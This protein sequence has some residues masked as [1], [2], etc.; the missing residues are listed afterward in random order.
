MPLT[1]N[2]LLDIEAAALREAA[3][4]E[5]HGRTG[6]ARDLKHI[7]S[8]A[9][10][11]ADLRFPCPASMDSVLSWLEDDDTLAAAC[12]STVPPVVMGRAA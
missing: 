8:D 1:R 6:R 3:I 9:A 12:G 5:H 4:A 7:A 10:S 11:A 2:E